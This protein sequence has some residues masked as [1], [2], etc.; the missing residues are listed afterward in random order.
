MNSFYDTGHCARGVL[1]AV[2]DLALCHLRC[3]EPRNA[4]TYVRGSVVNGPGEGVIFLGEMKAVEMV[5]GDAKHE[6]ANSLSHGRVAPPRR[7]KIKEKMAHVNHYNDLDKS[8]ARLD[9]CWLF[10]Q[11]LLLL[12]IFIVEPFGR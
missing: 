9:Q 4:S 5:R 8:K 12:W 2:P 7:A 1:H 3:P 6:Q 11:S 10:F